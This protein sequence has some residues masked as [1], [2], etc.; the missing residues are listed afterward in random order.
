VGRRESPLDP[1][2]GELARFAQALRDLRSGR[3][4]T[5]AQLAAS[6]HYSRSTLQEACAG[7]RLPSLDVTLAIAGACGGDEQ[8]WRSRWVATKSLLAPQDGV[9]GPP[10]SGT[11]QPRTPEPERVKAPA[12]RL[13]A[14]G[15]A[16]VAAVV[17]VVILA[18]SHDASA[19]ERPT[20]SRPP[21]P[22]VPASTW[23][24]QEF[25][26]GGAPSFLDP[27]SPA[28]EGPRLAF[29]QVVL[30]ACKVRA[31]SIPSVTPDG[32][33]YLVA[34]PPWNRHYYVAANTFLNGDPP[35]GPYTHNTDSQVRTC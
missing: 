5:Y 29:K 15:L 4:L 13:V 30:V 14:A 9:P 6:T 27:T 32:Y 28:G 1:E 16:A 24:E 33:W 18:W 8:Q 35:A 17:T 23:Q 21:S 2:G 25:H 10:G 7:R 34:S 3:N 31:P 22:S 20:H 12:G 19:P 26:R 11:R